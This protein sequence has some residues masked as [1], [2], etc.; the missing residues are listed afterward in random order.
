MN[1]KQV[2]MDNGGQFCQ[3]LDFGNFFQGLFFIQAI[4]MLFSILSEVFYENNTLRN[5]FETPLN[6]KI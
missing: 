6:I 2:I 1:I 5:G 4:I 3:S